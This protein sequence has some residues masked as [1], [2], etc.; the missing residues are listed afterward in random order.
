M[1]TNQTTRFFTFGEQP[2]E[3]LKLLSGESFGPITLAYQTYGTLNASR[4]NGILLFHAL[5][6]SQHAAGFNPSVPGVGERWTEECQTGW[7]DEFVGPGKALDTNRFFVVC[8]NYLGGCYGS[9]GPCSLNSD[10]GKPYGP[11]FPRITLSDIVDSQIH[12]L[13]HLNIDQ[14]HAVVGSSMGGM[15]AT[16]LAT[17][18][19][20]KTRL[21]I[22]IAANIRP[23]IL[24]R[25]HNLEQIMAIE[26]D[27]H[28]NK[29]RYYDSEPPRAG[30]ALARMISHKTF[31]SLGT[32]ERRARGEIMTRHDN[33][34]SYD[35]THTIES[36]LLHQVRKFVGRFDANT[37]LRLL[38]AWQH[39][40]LA[41][42]AGASSKEETF[43]RST[44][45]RYLIFSIDSDVCFYPEEQE[46]MARALTK[47][48]ISTQH[49]T[50]HSDKGHDAFLLEPALFTPYLAYTL[51]NA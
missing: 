37:Y 4:D 44:H 42:D 16:V 18:Y 30:L 48:G 22:P 13:D 49:I 34:L 24:Q 5:T 31:V 41:I 11:D 40:E 46:I 6:G 51:S 39:Y 36:Y 32:M 20:N 26:N 15:L 23:S 25:I 50:V 1:N 8:A 12:L 28:F 17:R 10:T 47:A 45:Q 38:D 9:S 2:S 35:L 43:A 3:R 21:V 33:L 14:L 27:P 7:W 29:G 19:P